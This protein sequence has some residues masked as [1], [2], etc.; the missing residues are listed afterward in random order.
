[1]RFRHGQT[2]IRG[3][4]G[5]PPTRREFHESRV[6]GVAG[7]LSRALDAALEAFVAD[8]DPAV[9]RAAT[10]AGQLD[11]E[12]R[13]WPP[14]DRPRPMDAGCPTRRRS[15]LWAGRSSCWWL[16]FVTGLL[17]QAPTSSQP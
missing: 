17:L 9:R 10:A 14:V 2:E 8:L 12:A 7:L 16:S 13:G 5:S 4:R 6:D 11:S 15:R 1:L 3:C